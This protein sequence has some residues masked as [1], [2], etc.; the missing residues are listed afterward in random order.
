MTYRSSID[1]AAPVERVWDVLMDVETWPD[2]SPT[3]TAVKRLEPGMFRPGSSARIKQPRLPES[4]WRVTAL[5]PQK[6]FTWATRSRGVTTVARHTV[7]AREEGGTRAR[8]EIDQ[9]GPLAL[10]AWIFFGRLT[11]RYMEQEGQ[12][13]K[14]RCER[15]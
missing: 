13:L 14:K 11:R 12:E 7:A 9:S 2:W 8:S 4:T 10:L 15:G 1:I 6:S 5:V 3:M